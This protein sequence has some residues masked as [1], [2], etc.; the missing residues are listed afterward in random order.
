[1]LV[2]VVHCSPEKLNENLP[3]SF[4]SAKDMISTIILVIFWFLFYFCV[5][6]FV[7][8]LFVISSFVCVCVCVRARCFFWEGVYVWRF[9]LITRLRGFRGSQ[10]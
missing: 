7:A 2:F 9:Y 8:T 6:V 10:Q 5:R 3:I 4:S 1:M